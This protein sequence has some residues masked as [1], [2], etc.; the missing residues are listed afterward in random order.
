MKK[1]VLINFLLVILLFTIL[2]PQILVLHG[3]AN[4]VPPTGGPRD[5]LPPVLVRA[6]PPDSG[7]LFKSKTITFTFDEFVKV[8][9]LQENLLISPTPDVQPLVEAKL[10]TVTVKLKD[11]LEPGTTYVYNFGNAI[12]DI[13][14]SNVL[15]N[16]TYIFSSGSALDSLELQGRVL[17]AESGGIDSALIVMLHRNGDDSAVVKE[18]PRYITR[19]DG[20]GYFHFRFLPAGTFYLYALQDEGGSKRYMSGSQLFAFSDSAV[21]IKPGTGSRILYAYTEKKEQA[22]PSISFG[23]TR[24]S[25]GDERRLRFSTSLANNVQDLLNQLILN[26]EHP[27]RNIDTSKLQVS[28][29]SSFKKETNY[30]WETDSLKKKLTMQIAWKEN[31][32]YNLILDKDFAEDTSGRKLFK[33]DT[34]SFTTRKSSDY[35][36]VKITFTKLDLTKNP[37]LQFIQGSQVVK[38]VPVT[39][40]G[41]Y[42]PL[43]LPGEYELRM[44]FDEN[45]NG[46]WDAGE[47][48]RK[49]KLPEIV[50]PLNKKITVRA[51]WDNELEIQ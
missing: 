12:K 30:Q 21:E 33:T 3:C 23:T 22:A 43:F 17:L 4:I 42:M 18:K 47:F 14:E 7:T 34:L 40:A 2:I 5:T 9:N 16:F 27:L 44:L 41:V 28:T 26:F 49:K 32:R 13:N 51:N 29:D 10:R 8:E 31:T 19:L 38:S 39:A 20:K 36:S 11:T 25:R 48:F 37:V 45:K 46:Q 50:V 35:G 1:A 24:S 15:R 6:N